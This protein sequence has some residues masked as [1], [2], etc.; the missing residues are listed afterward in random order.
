MF[1]CAGNGPSAL[2]LS[3]I[4][5]GHVPYYTGGHHDRLLHSKLSKQPCLLDIAPDLYEHF[6]SSLRYSTQA[7]PINTLLDTLIRPN[8]DTEV[9]ARS[10]V[11]WLYE[12]RKAVS[13]VALGNTRQPGGQWAENPVAAS[14][15]IGT[16]SY[17]EMLSLPEYSLE[18]HFKAT[19]GTGMPEF[20]RPS[21]REVADYYAA[22]PSKVGIEETIIDSEQVIGVSRTSKGFYIA[23]HGIRC[24]HLVLASGI[25][26]ISLPPP[27]LLAP[28]V[29][30]DSPND[31]LLVIGSGFSAADVIISTSPHRKI[32]HV[33]QWHP[34]ER[35]SP[36]RGC[37]HQAYPEYA[38]VYR[39]MKL[40]AISSESHRTAKSPLMR[41]KT[42][43]FF[44]QR[45]WA[46][47]YEG[48]PNAEIVSIEPLNGSTTI[49]FRLESGK[50]VDRTVGGLQYVVGRRGTLDFL[51]ANLRSEILNLDSMSLG[52][53][54]FISGRTLRRKA[55]ESFEMATNAFLIGSLAG[56]SLVR[57]AFGGC[58]SVAGKVLHRNGV[59][60]TT[61]SNTA[62]RTT[63]CKTG[64]SIELAV[65]ASKI[66]S[67]STLSAGCCKSSTNSPVLRPN[68]T[69]HEDLH[70]DRRK[71][72]TSLD[73]AESQNRVWQESGWWAAGL[74][75][76]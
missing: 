60:T 15:D 31:P 12:P 47:V 26:S 23:S 19:H 62:P 32:I 70:L 1:H 37:H 36:L 14:W 10:C 52:N 38:G 55:E 5:H 3:Y 4:L 20:L 43:P 61:A 54:S 13:H 33:Y 39:Q 35:P 22:Y 67:K 8:A 28:I 58:V 68:G 56:D 71:M 2:I 69:E 42:N 29:T 74:R 41:R 7:L 40:A 72:I 24:K 17:A 65:A 76:G 51:E 16:L 6:S 44:N 73:L 27:P 48:L 57:H 50:L 9:N 25:F 66:P 21:R 53:E 34:D 11:E 30:L 64:D 18:D 49:T 63:K 45:D 46:S 59:S 75:M